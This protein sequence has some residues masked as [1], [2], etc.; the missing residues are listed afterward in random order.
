MRLVLGRVDGTLEGSTPG[1]DHCHQMLLL[2][3]LR[4]TSMQQEE[5]RKSYPFLIFSASFFS[6][7][8][9]LFGVIKCHL[10]MHSGARLSAVRGCW[11]EARGETG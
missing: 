3:L 6:S 4:R 2:A 10:L 1:A 8:S 7:S 11:N 5:E 9:F